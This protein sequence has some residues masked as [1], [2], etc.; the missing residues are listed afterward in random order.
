MQSKK[1]AGML[2]RISCSKAQEKYLLK[3]YFAEYLCFA[4]NAKHEVMQVK[5]VQNQQI[6]QVQLKLTLVWL[7]KRK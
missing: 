5:V 7:V 3:Y 1:K 6:F 4:Q 2:G